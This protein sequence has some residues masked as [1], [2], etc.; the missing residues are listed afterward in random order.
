MKKY[1]IFFLA[2]GLLLVNCKKDDEVL[3]TG[4]VDPDP[5]ADVVAQDFIWKATNLYY[6]WQQDVPNLA[7][8][9]F[10]TSADYTEFLQSESNP[11]ELFDNKL[12]FNEDRFTFYRADYKELVNSLSGIV[13]S[14]G[15]EYSLVYFFNSDEVF[16]VVQYVLPNSDASTKDIKRG[17]I[18][19]G[20]NGQTLFSPVLRRYNVFCTRTGPAGLR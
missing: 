6:F 14:D 11:G 13:P 19:T 1:L 10:A 5:S 2:M 12:R 15:L 4:G 16:G 18:F 17:D 9:R 3:D 20:V 7:D 8:D